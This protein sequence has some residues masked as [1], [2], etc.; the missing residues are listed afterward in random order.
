MPSVRSIR[1][2]QMGGGVVWVAL[3]PGWQLPTLPPKQ[4]Q[5]PE[6]PWQRIT[7]P[8]AEVPDLADSM[9]AAEDI[10]VTNE[11]PCTIDHF[12]ANPGTSKRE[13]EHT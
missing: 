1:G 3:K 11:I 9:K 13:N 4:Q 6:A 10:R 2:E 5:Q 7:A 12:F 8:F